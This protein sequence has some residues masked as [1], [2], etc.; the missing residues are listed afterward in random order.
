[1]YILV[2]PEIFDENDCICHIGQSGG[3]CEK[4]KP[5]IFNRKNC[6]IFIIKYFN[7]LKF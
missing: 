7:H 5:G 3:K 1:M 2:Y 4:S 6:E